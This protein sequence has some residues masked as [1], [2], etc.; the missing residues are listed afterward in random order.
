MLKAPPPDQ[1][2][3]PSGMRNLTSGGTFLL[4]FLRIN[5]PQC[6]INEHTG[7]LLVGPNALWPTQPKFCVIFTVCTSTLLFLQRDAMHSVVMRSHVVCPSVRPSVCPSVTFR[8]HDHIGWNTLKIISRLNSLRP[9][10]LL[11]PT[12]V[13]WCNENTPKIR[14]E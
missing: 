7:Q 6:R 12:W 2:W 1:G 14:A 4:I 10:R 3:S 8:Y 11:A 13:I 9:M 5:W